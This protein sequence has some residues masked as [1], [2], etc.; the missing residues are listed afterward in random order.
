MDTILG[1]AGSLFSGVASGG[2]F[3]MIGSI[4]GVAAKFFQ[5]RQR[6]AW[7]Q[8]KWAHEEALIE[9]QMKQKTAETE[10]EI[11]LAG[12]EGSWRGLAESQ[13]AEAS[14]G[15]TSQW[16]NNLRSMFRPFL[17]IFLWVGA[18]VLIWMMA[19]GVLNEFIDAGT[20]N[21]LIS[22]TINSVVFAASTATVWWFGDRAFTPPGLK[23]R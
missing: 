7:E 13:R 8:K 17:T 18:G 10:A 1:L 23:R 4:V 14:I 22:Y 3:G 21:E 6:Q 11:A 5:E 9:L 15:H 19:R 2:I 20:A 16:V 12:A